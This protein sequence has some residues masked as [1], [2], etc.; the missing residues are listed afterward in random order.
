[1]ILIHA[2][3]LLGNGLFIYAALPEVRRT[4]RAGKALAT[5]LDLIITVLLGFVV[6]WIYTFLSRGWDIIL[7]INYG[8]QFVIWGILLYYRLFRRMK[9]EI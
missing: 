2:L 9:N 5:P 3:G 8:M 7:A 1:M 6:M 4:I